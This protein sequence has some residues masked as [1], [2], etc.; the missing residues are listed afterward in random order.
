MEKN[1]FASVVDTACA[2]AEGKTVL[3]IQ[4]LLC[5]VPT[6]GMDFS[7]PGLNE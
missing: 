4:L 2:P 6:V 1:I 5:V 3:V 7:R